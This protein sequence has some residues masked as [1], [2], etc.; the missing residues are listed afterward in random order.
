MKLGI[1]IVATV[2]AQGKKNWFKLVKNDR[3]NIKLIKWFKVPVVRVIFCRPLWSFQNLNFG[4]S[5][6]AIWNFKTYQII[7]RTRSVRDFS[8]LQRPLWNRVFSTVHL[9]PVK[10]GRKEKKAYQIIFSTQDHR[11]FFGLSGH[12]W[13]I[14]QF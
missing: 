9:K 10:N 12:F 1:A 14:G 6:N 3:G 8:C 4:R 7:Q 11:L 13:N 5:K 2:A